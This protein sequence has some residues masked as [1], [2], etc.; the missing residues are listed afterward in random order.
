MCDV[1]PVGLAEI[2]DLL[3]VPPN[4]V[5]SW[6]QRGALPE[7]RWRLKSGPVWD[8]D[9]VR[10][11]HER[12]KGAPSMPL[13]PDRFAVALDMSTEPGRAEV[14]AHYGLAM[15]EAQ[16]IE[17]HLAT[18]LALLD[19]PEPYRHEMFAEIIDE[20]RDQTMGELAARLRKRNAP[21]L[22]VEYLRR[23][24]DTRNLLAHRYF[25]D[26]QRSLKMTTDEGRADLI[27][28]LATAARDF[29]LTTQHLRAAEVRLAL[30][31]GVDRSTVMER[32]RALANGAVP[33]G[34]LA[35][36]AATLVSGMPGVVEVVERAFDDVEE[37]QGD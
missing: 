19:V 26:P 18:V 34:S 32:A 9:E 27:A 22:G 25:R 8:A 5:A 2:S 33:E 35:E 36:R 29:H 23:I 24:K 16:M 12:E 10:A 3:G 21:V 30:D 20:A 14:F 31:H 13:P 6:R 17:E 1:E 4:T 11:W 15:G 7:P 37:H 28:E